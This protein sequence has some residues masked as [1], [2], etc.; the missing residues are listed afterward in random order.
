MIGPVRAVIVG[1]G[2]IGRR[3][4]TNL[5]RVAPETEIAVWHH[6]RREVAEETAEGDAVLYDLD[7]VLAFRPEFAILANPA[8][9]HVSVA[10]ALV[11]NGVHLLI[12]KP[13]SHTVDGVAEL[14]EAAERHN[15]IVSVGYTLRFDKS[16]QEA[17]RLVLDG[18]VGRIASI[19]A[20]V[21][22]YLPDWRPATDYR[23]AVSARK[24]LGGGVVLE[25]SHEIDYVRWIGGEV[26]TVSAQLGRLGDL[27]IDVEDTAEITLRMANGILAHI[28]LDMI[29]RSPVRRCR[30][31]G[32]HGTCLWDGIR[33]R[34]EVY[35]ADKQEWAT[36]G[37]PVAA[38]RNETYLAELEAFLECVRTGKKA[39]IT[40]EDG[41]RDLEIALAVKRSHAEQQVIRL[42]SSE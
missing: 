21:G 3:H 5:R 42:R 14:I 4:L 15:V 6:R 25:L 16:L 24:K 11:A 41:L 31:T 13:L 30:I 38:D 17:R 36:V 1:L 35:Y 19:H 40:G 12:E 37:Q 7:S 20:E 18:T 9:F 2:S 29:Q 32:T 23:E 27:E 33:S 26:A 34:V 22:S 28:H 39:A 10:Q 8:P